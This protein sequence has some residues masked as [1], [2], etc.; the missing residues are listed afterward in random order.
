MKLNRYASRH[1][2]KCLALPALLLLA[3]RAEALTLLPSSPT[4]LDRIQVTIT[5]RPLLGCN[6][7]FNQ[8]P[9]ISG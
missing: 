5:G 1:R 3:S 9:Q 4:S 2:T 8:S 6:P 7:V